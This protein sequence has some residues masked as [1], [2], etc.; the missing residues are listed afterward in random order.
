MKINKA[1]ETKI[2]K[3]IAQIKNLREL[4]T[5]GKLIL[6]SR[7]LRAMTFRDF[8]YF[9][10]HPEVDEWRICLDLEP[11]EILDF[12]RG[13]ISLCRKSTLLKYAKK[14]GLQLPYNENEYPDVFVIGTS[15]CIRTRVNDI[16]Y[17][18]GFFGVYE[19]LTLDEFLFKYQKNF[20]D[21]FDYF[22]KSNNGWRK[23]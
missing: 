22:I 6:R 2:I 21:S 18:H 12:E 14:R 13:L 7:N 20:S 5:T 10:I 8:S 3:S 23:C 19:P 11:I 4:E 1:R 17:L 15:I 9:Y 16:T